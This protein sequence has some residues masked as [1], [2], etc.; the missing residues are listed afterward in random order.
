MLLPS[1]ISVVHVFM[2]L[3]LQILP[4]NSMEHFILQS[5]RHRAV[6][7]TVQLDSGLADCTSQDLCAHTGGKKLWLEATEHL[8]KGFSAHMHI[9]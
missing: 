9:L 5:H 2:G 7:T 1:A 6:H 8:F 3:I 4:M